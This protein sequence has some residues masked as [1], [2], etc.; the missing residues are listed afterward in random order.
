[1]RRPPPCALHALVLSPNFP[2]PF[3]WHLTCPS[4]L[5]CFNASPPH[6]GFPSS[7]L[8]NVTWDH[9]TAGAS[10][11][12]W[13]TGRQRWG[14]GYGTRADEAW[15]G[16]PTLCGWVKSYGPVRSGESMGERA[17]GLGGEADRRGR[18]QKRAGWQSLKRGGLGRRASWEE[19]RGGLQRALPS[20]PTA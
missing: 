11:R 15:A 7:S 2:P 20:Q 9:L 1:M 14:R 4:A 6:P 10:L 12:S 5:F 19:G 17:G 3:A 18:M 13:V 16:C 8:N